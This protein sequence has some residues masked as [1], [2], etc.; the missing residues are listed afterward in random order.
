MTH[1]SLLN[2]LWTTTLTRLGGEG[3]ITALARETKAFQRPREIKS[4]VNLPR[5]VLA[6]CLGGM[7]L[8]TTSA[9]ASSIGLADVSNVAL[10]GRLRNCT[11]WMER[12]VGR[13]L[14]D[15]VR[16]AAQ[17]RPFV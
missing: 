11:A 16:A 4:A 10:L 6:Y 5:F 8:R 15:D 13:L 7:G 17:G 14:A 1:D 3:T 2:E 12:L 9:W